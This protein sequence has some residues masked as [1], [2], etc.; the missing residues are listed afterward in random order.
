MNESAGRA[1][2]QRALDELLRAD[3]A[4]RLVEAEARR[5]GERQQ[6][7]ERAQILRA[8]LAKDDEAAR[9]GRQFA[10]PVRR[11]DRGRVSG[12][13]QKQGAHVHA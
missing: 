3:F 8:D 12:H 7:H 9:Q 4:D 2:A 6:V 5:V 1:I 13:N 11:A 10:A